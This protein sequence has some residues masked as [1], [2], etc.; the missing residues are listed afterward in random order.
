MKLTNPGFAR[1]LHKRSDYHEPFY[2]VLKEK[3]IFEN[4][5]HCFDHGGYG[6]T[7]VP[8]PKTNVGLFIRKMKT[9]KIKSK[10]HTI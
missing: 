5:C 2:R 1:V 9:V 6:Y 7:Q 3:D 10:Y 8:V 4:H